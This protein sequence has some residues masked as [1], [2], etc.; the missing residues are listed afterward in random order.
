ML[1]RGKS[2]KRGRAELE[3]WRVS[4]P[5]SWRREK[6]ANDSDNNGG[7]STVNT[8]TREKAKTF[9]LFPFLLCC[10]RLT[11]GRIRGNERKRSE[12]DSPDSD[13]KSNLET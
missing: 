4:E 12:G 6:T 3:G 9:K 10:F 8:N 1:T 11:A 13:N 2:G 7:M 5:K